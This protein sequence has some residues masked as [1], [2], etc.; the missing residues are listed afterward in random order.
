MLDTQHVNRNTY[1]LST[2]KKKR[3]KNTQYIWGGGETPWFQVRYK[4]GIYI[5]C[6]YIIQGRDTMKYYALKYFQKQAQYNIKAVRLNN[7]QTSHYM[8]GKLITQIENYL[9]QSN[10]L[11]NK[12]EYAVSWQCNINKT[13]F[14][15][16]NIMILQ[17]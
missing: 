14:D 15:G 1:I 17:I 4:D 5:H 7:L 8:P 9:R 10:V 11:N 16:I 13:K 6:N 3:K 12:G 2:K